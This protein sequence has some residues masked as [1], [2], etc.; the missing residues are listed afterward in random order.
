MIKVLNVID[1]LNAGGA[2]SLLKNFLIEAKK[3]SGFQID[4]C[5]LYARNIFKE[6]LEK[7]D[8]TTFDLGLKFKYDF[9]GIV[10]I[11]SLIK[12]NNYDIV[13]V[14][15]FPADLFVAIASLFLPKSIKFIF[16]EHNVYNRRRSL[17]AYKPIDYFVYSRYDKI[18]CVSNHVKLALNAYIQGTKNKSVVIKNAIPIDS[19]FIETP[20]IYD[21][22]FVGRLEDAK[23]V[24]VLIKAI[25]ILKQKFNLQ[26]K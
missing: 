21:V 26:L 25:A 9:S 20:K 5:T 11:V 1:S 23:G 19:N 17:K 18:I 2:E 6:D 10:K 8:I 22:L 16:S 4:V 14:H 12:Q 13:H 7:N 15:L 3:Y 24:D